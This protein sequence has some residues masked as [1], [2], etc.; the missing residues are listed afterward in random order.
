MVVGAHRQIY[1]KEMGQSKLQSFPRALN[2]HS[3]K[4]KNDGEMPVKC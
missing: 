2:G 1:G 4:D 3:G